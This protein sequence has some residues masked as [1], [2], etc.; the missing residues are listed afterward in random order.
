MIARHGA[1]R[2]R[3]LVVPAIAGVGGFPVAHEGVDKGGL[4]RRHLAIIGVLF[5]AGGRFRTA[6]RCRAAQGVDPLL[7]VPDRRDP[8]AEVLSHLDGPAGSDLLVR[9]QDLQILV[10]VLGQLDD[11][12]GGEGHHVPRKH[13]AV[14]DLHDD[15]HVE[16]EDEIELLRHLGCIGKI[17]RRA[18]NLRDASGSA[19]AA[20]T[21]EARA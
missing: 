12:P 3:N 2:W 14:G 20:S 21:K 18:C 8:H 4:V 7:E 9:H 10:R 5:V 17:P 15:R 6:A 13:V 19:D 16:L 11:G 1:A